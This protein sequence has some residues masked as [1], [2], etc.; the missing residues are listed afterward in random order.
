VAL[1]ESGIILTHVANWSGDQETRF[2]VRNA[3]GSILSK[4][5]YSFNYPLDDR[6]A[7]ADEATK[8]TFENQ[9]HVKDKG[10]T[11]YIIEKDKKTPKY[12]FQSKRSI[13][14]GSLTQR[15][16]DEAPEYWSIIETKT[17]LYFSFFLQTGEIVERRNFF[18]DK[19]KKQTYAYRKKTDEYYESVQNDMDDSDSYINLNQTNQILLGFRL[20]FEDE[21]LTDAS[22]HIRNKIRKLRATVQDEDPFFMLIMHLKY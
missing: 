8:Y 11:L 6:S 18:Y 5:K 16:Y 2:V 10:D 1:V 15:R 9:L 19:E 7:W 14:S 22:P 17:G 12:V 20:D 3:E 4:Y 13:H 21:K